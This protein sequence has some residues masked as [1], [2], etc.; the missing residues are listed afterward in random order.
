MSSVIGSAMQSVLYGSMALS[1]TVGASLQYL[2]GMI[3]T[4]QLLTHTP[5]F[6][7]NMPANVMLFL[8]D[9]YGIV[10]F[11]LLANANQI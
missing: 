10:N 7:I 11:N 2:W 5:L 3:N 9:I 1:L 8:S 6:S 4:L